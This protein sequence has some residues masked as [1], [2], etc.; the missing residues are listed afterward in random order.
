MK[1]TTNLLEEELL[2]RLEWFIYIR[3]AAIVFIILLFLTALNLFKIILPAR[4]IFLLALFIAIYNAGFKLY[5]KHKT[6]ST[7]NIRR[8]AI[9]QSMLDIISLTILIHFTGGAENPF[10]F[11]FIF[12][13]IFTSMLLSK[14]ESYIQ[15]GIICFLVVGL[16]IFEYLDAMPHYPVRGFLNTDIYK[17]SAY[18]TAIS[19]VFSSTIFIATFFTASVSE[20][21]RLKENELKEIALKLLEKDRQKDEYVKM[22]SHDLKSPLASIQSLLEVILG[23]FAGV[24]DEKTK[25]ILQRIY[26]KTE[27]LHH[28]TKDLLDLSRIRAERNL[29]LQRLNIKDL[30]YTAAEI[31]LPKIGEKQIELKVAVDEE[32]SE[33]EADKEL[34]IHV[35][36][37]LIAN[38]FKYTPSGG[39][40]LV[41][42]SQSDGFIIVEVK[43]TGIGI[44][45]ED[46]P[47]MF[48][49]FFRA[50]NV[51]KTT[52]G[53]GLGL[54]LAKYIIERHGGNIS[55]ESELGKGTIFR[56]TIPISNNP[57]SPI[58]I[59]AVNATKKH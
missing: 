27:F 23:G 59:K 10:I 37:N 20:R 47:H 41:K 56:F 18:L 5:L 14:K 38:A 28:Y 2:Q 7:A 36:A 49:E 16:F 54:S 9:I 43:D 34:I 50:G 39:N 48:E 21:L 1:Q 33:I 42:V 12:H 35:L 26:K 51:A 25:E 31:V 29:N 32:T 13:T 57:S 58:E 53:T 55:I 44:P 52:K 46:M 8:F 45:A 6:P 4:I 30:I 22:V 40:V 3:W 15:A 11:Y 19:F 24:A 17:N